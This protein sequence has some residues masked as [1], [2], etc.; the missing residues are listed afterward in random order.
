MRQKVAS[1]SQ[2]LAAVVHNYYSVWY[3]HATN[4]VALFT[5]NARNFNALRRHSEFYNFILQFSVFTDT[6]SVYVRSIVT[7]LPLQVPTYK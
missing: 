1:K 2:T 5:V 6:I 7:N 3:I 4:L